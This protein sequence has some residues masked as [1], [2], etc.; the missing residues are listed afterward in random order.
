[1]NKEY[2][3]LSQKEVRRLKILHKV[4][5][6]DVT[7][8]KAAEILGISD[9]QIRNIIVKLKEEGDKGIVHGNRGVRPVRWPQNNR[10]S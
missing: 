7:Q 1:M 6:G 2:I 4:M 9:R 5:E 3:T 8:I 10:N